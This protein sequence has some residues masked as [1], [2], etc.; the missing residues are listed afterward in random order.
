[1][2][3]DPLLQRGG[4]AVGVELALLDLIERGVHVVDPFRAE[5][6]RAGPLTREFESCKITANVVAPGFVDTDITAVGRTRS[7]RSSASSP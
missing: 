4:R 2:Q 1:V 3:P 5:Q 6:V 7:P